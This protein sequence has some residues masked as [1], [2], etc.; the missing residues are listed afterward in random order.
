MTERLFPQTVSARL[1]KAGFA[2]SKTTRG[3]IRGLSERSEGFEVMAWS[4]GAVRV[5]HRM[6]S[7]AR[8]DQSE[9][10]LAM[11]D[12]YGEALAKGGLSWELTSE[13]GMTPALIVTKQGK[14]DG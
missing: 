12:K 11:L 9:S 3:R 13:A 6:S 4:D 5:V 8:G 10:I 2:R 7:F 14:A 1:T